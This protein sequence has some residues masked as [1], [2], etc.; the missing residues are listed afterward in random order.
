MVDRPLG[1]YSKRSDVFATFSIDPPS[2]SLPRTP[3]RGATPAVQEGN[4][5][6]AIESSLVENLTALPF[7]GGLEARGQVRR[8]CPGDKLVC[9]N[10]C[11]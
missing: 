9:S 7:E 8:D 2:R 10:S 6:D 3:I 11:A 1:E 5:V 4:L